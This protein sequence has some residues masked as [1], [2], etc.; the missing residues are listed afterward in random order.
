MEY[1]TDGF[2]CKPWPDMFIVGV[3]VYAE[4][5]AKKKVAVFDRNKRVTEIQVFNIFLLNKELY[6]GESTV[7]FNFQC[8]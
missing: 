4:L 2:K 1:R 3:A 5:F 8:Y 7:V 6:P